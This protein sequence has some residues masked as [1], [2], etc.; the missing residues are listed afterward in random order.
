MK[1][2]SI[3]QSIFLFL[4]V[5]LFLPGC[6]NYSRWPTPV[7]GSKIVVQSE[8]YQPYELLFIQ[9]DGSNIQTAAMKENFVKPV[10]SANGKRIF[11]LSNPDWMPAYEEI[12]YPAYWDIENNHFVRCDRDMIYFNQIEE[13]QNSDNPAEVILYDGNAKEFIL[14]DIDTC[15]EIEQLGEITDQSGSTL[16]SGFTFS[17]VTQELVYGEIFRPK[18]GQPG[19]RLMRVNL[20]TGEKDVLVEGINPVWSPDGTQIAY[21]GLEGLYLLDLITNQSRLFVQIDS[22]ATWNDGNHWMI[23]PQPRWSPDGKWLVLHKCMS[24][25]CVVSETQILKIRVADGLLETIHVGGKFP[26]WRN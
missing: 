16:I 23:A 5:L 19:F 11:G 22:F 21:V 7:Q 1:K 2:L 6:T 15:Q 20:N 9:P 24:E 10:W 13:Y 3:H 4:V 12:G 14:F 8:M 18:D 17:A 26:S 25:R